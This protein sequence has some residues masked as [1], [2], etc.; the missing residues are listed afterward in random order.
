MKNMESIEELM[1]ILSASNLTELSFENDEIKI[2][3]KANNNKINKNIKKEKVTKKIEEKKDE[4]LVDVLSEHIGK[5]KTKVK[6][7]DKIKVGQD[8][9]SVSAMGVSMP[10]LSK[11]SGIIEKIYVEDGGKVDYGKPLF[12]VKIQK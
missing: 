3:L 10:S 11:V 8:L 5:F 2:N 4:N 6:I 7:G 12:N 9:G 1:K